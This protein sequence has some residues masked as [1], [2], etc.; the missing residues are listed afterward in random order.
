M[1]HLQHSVSG[2]L[3]LQTDRLRR[4]RLRLMLGRSLG[5][6]WNLLV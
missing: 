5:S 4:Q 1:R 3:L 2:L 6:A